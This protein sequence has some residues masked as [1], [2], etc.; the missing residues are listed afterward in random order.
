MSLN[1][2]DLKQFDRD[3]VLEP[4]QIVTAKEAAAIADRVA[5]DVTVETESS[6]AIY[7]FHSNRDVHLYS[8]TLFALAT[9]P[10]LIEMLT[11]LLGPNVILWR[12]TA[13]YKPGLGQ[14]SPGIF[15]FG[16]ID[17]HQGADFIKP[18][19][20]MTGLYPSIGYSRE[21]N[22]KRF[23]LNITAWIAIDPADEESGTLMF[24]R[25]SHRHGVVPYEPISGEIGFHQTGLKFAYEGL[26]TQA[27]V[28]TIPV[29]GGSC[30]LF[31]N[32][33]LHKSNPNRSTR[34]RLGIACRYVSS[35]TPVYRNGDPAGYD[36]S[37]W[38]CVQVA[39]TPDPSVNRILVPHEIPALAKNL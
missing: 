34:R 24:A 38:G 27:D 3:G 13:F 19:L 17:W 5:A 25:G 10:S 4:K 1:S 39:G 32:F 33:V 18:A 11:E 36:L 23:P 31:N 20:D 28:T 8:P 2:D 9:H 30:L 21:A 26:F 37:N 6:R 16:N 7:G 15:G 29:P 12:S 14:P 35:R 22:L